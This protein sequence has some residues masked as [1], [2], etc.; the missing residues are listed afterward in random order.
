MERKKTR[1]RSSKGGFMDQ[2]KID[3]QLENRL[4]RIDSDIAAEENR[5]PIEEYDRFFFTTELYYE[6]ALV[7]AKVIRC[8]DRFNVHTPQGYMDTRGP[9]CL[10]KPLDVLGGDPDGLLDLESAILA[11]WSQAKRVY[12]KFI[13]KADPQLLDQEV[14]LMAL[15]MGVTEEGIVHGKI[16]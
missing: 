10:F 16:F 2:N 5:L 14:R 7:L 6:D 8:K 11:R 3:R 1:G 9:W 4:S 15:L 12:T 13:Y